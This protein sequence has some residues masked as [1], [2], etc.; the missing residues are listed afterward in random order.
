MGEPR[1]R[2]EVAE[3]VVVTIASGILLT[4]A[5]AIGWLWLRRPVAPASN[6]FFPMTS[7]SW[8]G[9]AN[10]CTGRRVGEIAEPVRAR[11]RETR[12]ATAW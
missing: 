2:R 9:T 3:R 10:R 12:P 5:G 11:R 7:T 8:A 4:L 1:R 6:S